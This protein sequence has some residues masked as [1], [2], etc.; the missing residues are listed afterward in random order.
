MR[1]LYLLREY[2]T[3]GI[4]GEQVIVRADGEE[5][6]RIK[7]PLLDQILV[8]GNLQL[9]TA[10]IKACLNRGIQI[11]YLSRNGWCYG[12]TQSIQG[13]YRHRGRHQLLL[14]ESDRINAA[15]SLIAGKISNARVLLLRLT[16]RDRRDQV[17]NAIDRLSWHGQQIRKAKSLER[18]RGL[19]GNAA[20]EYFQALGSLLEGNGFAFLGRHR[21]P[22]TTPFDAL[23]GFSYSVLWN[24]LLTRIELQGL[25]P[26]EG[27]LHVGSARH[28]ALVSD[29]IE[30]LRTLLADPFNVWMIRTRRIQADIGFEVRDGGVF[31]TEAYRKLWLKAWSNYMAEQICLANQMQGPR[32]ELLDGLVRSF[33]RYVYSPSE[34]IVVPQRR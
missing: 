18:I 15:I 1:S 24:A 23:C 21:Q 14:T 30:P 3:A 4:E 6:E 22:P 2:G 25:D 9:S 5:V 31:L 11:A 12:R 10:L 28:A 34:G 8:M 32:W 19:E 16:R 17:A 20:A 27:V 26:Y 7:L 33:V 13:G 29:L